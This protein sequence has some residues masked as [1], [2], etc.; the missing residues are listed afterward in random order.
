MKL[1]SLQ[2][3]PDAGQNYYRYN[4][5]SAKNNFCQMQEAE[6]YFSREVFFSKDL[7]IQ[8]SIQVLCYQWWQLRE[9]NIW[10]QI[11]F[12]GTKLYLVGPTSVFVGM[13]KNCP[14]RKI[15]GDTKQ[16]FR[17]VKD[18]IWSH[19][20]IFGWIKLYMVGPNLVVPNKKLTNY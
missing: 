12:V 19:Q 17:G 4:Y 5:Y 11:I 14:T 8:I 20:I 2:Q 6:I 1:P 15:F 13:K 18:I 10:S 3:Q 16:C 7:L 9:K